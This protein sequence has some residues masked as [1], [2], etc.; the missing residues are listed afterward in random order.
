MSEPDLSTAPPPTVPTVS[1]AEKL[2]KP[3]DRWLGLGGIVAGIAFFLVPKTPGVV[4]VCVIGIFLLLL[5]PLLRFW[6]IEDTQA[7]KLAAVG[8]WVV[9]CVLL[10]YFSWPPPIAKPPTAG[11]IAGEVWKRAPRPIAAPAQPTSSPIESSGKSNSPQPSAPPTVNVPRS[12]TPSRESL[13]S[14]ISKLHAEGLAFLMARDINMPTST[15]EDQQKWPDDPQ[16]V[17]NSQTGSKFMEQYGARL[18]ALRSKMIDSKVWSAA[19]EK[20]YSNIRY[21]FES[22]IAATA[23]L[24]DMEEAAS[25]LK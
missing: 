1:P 23:L 14:E 22:R 16:T 12:A 4:V 10:A 13:R 15:Q 9:A 6:W 19:M 11:E 2:S 7:R 8:T 24:D 25:R 5:H 18:I 3:I 21:P 20:S 17:Y